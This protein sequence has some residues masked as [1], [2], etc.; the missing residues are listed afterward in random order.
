MQRG[1]LR[2]VFGL[3]LLTGLLLLTVVNVWQSNRIERNQIDLLNRV[4]AVEKTIE[5]GD[6]GARGTNGPSGGIFGAAEP[7]YVTEALADPE[8]VFTRDN[9]SWLPAE[10]KQGGTLNLKMG[11][12]PKGFNFLVENGA[13]VSEIQSYVHIALGGYHL[14]DVTR[15]RGELAYH[16]TISE[17]KRVHTLKL[18]KDFQWHKPVVDWASG[19]YDWLKG[20]HPVTAHDVVFMLDLLMNDQVAGAAPLRSY[21]DELESYEALDDHTF[22]I[23]FKKPKYM[24]KVVVTGLY[25]LPKFLYAFDEAGEAYEPEVIGKRFEDHWYNPMGLGAGPYKLTRFEPGV[26]IELERNARFPLGGNAMDKIV[27]SI[28]KDQ[29]QPPRKLRT[30]ELHLSSLQPAQYRAEVLEGEADS[31]FKN[32]DLKGGEFW[33]YN[34]F[35]IGWNADQ[36]YFADKRVR[37]AMSHAFNAQLLIDD[38]FLGLGERCTGPMPTVQP[39][40]DRSLDPY[41]F[42]LERA[43]AL[44]D[45]AGWTDTD[46]DGIRDKLVDGESVPFDFK[47]VVFGSSNEY[48]TVG[49]IYKEDLAKIGVKMNVAP[50]EWANLLKKVDAREFDAV[51]LA[52]V[53]GPPVDFRQI[54]HSSQADLPK[55]SNRVGFRNPEADRIIE[56]LEVEFDER[57]RR[58][59][60]QEFHR[61]LYDEQPYTFFYTRKSTVYWQKELQNVWFQLTRPHVSPRPFY[62]AG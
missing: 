15:Y 29:N 23:S 42:D 3:I 12:D 47:L 60:A 9:S 56:A 20:D 14:K 41:A 35:Y 25:P 18:R 31:P 2:S 51:T 27:Y 21:F 13:D 16:W 33:S 53:S 8:N 52:W 10:A 43:K 55:G 26:A 62:F 40:Y 50:M 48:K 24:Q 45:E 4:D 59:L 5:N 6:F 57:K 46:G 49:N 11:S 61:L 30:G 17:D 28:L 34:Y 58:E 22:R 38:V 7:A 32:G 19:R 39:Y 1:F 44:L 54:W 37:Q 36:P